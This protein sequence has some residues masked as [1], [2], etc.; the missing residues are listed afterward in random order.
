M[1]T[2]S[3]ACDSALPTAILFH[4]PRYPSKY[5]DW[6]GI[7]TSV[8]FPTRVTS[9]LWPLTTIRLECNL[10]L[11]ISEESLHDRS[12]KRT[13]QLQPVPHASVGLGRSVKRTNELHPLRDASVGLGQRVKRTNQLHPLRDASVGFSRSVKRTNQL[14]PWPDASVASGL[15]CPLAW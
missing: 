3:A 7:T 12:V 14:H 1:C 6:L 4:Q 13:N 15:Y 11:A 10:I 5:S 2:W 8:C 9:V